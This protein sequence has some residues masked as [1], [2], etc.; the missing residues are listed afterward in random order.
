MKEI[1]KKWIC[2]R[3]HQDNE[4]AD[5]EGDCDRLEAKLEVP[6]GR[7]EHL[8]VGFPT[9]SSFFCHG[10]NDEEFMTDLPIQ[11]IVGGNSTWLIL[12]GNSD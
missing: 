6:L 1:R 11:L 3:F 9:S 10:C 4:G 7:E 12:R 8:Q 5:L 2:K